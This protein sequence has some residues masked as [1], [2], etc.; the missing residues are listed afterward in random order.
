MVVV[1]KGEGMKVYIIWDDPLNMTVS[2]GKLR[3]STASDDLERLLDGIREAKGYRPMFYGENR[4]LEGW[5]DFDFFIS[6]NGI[7]QL[8]ATVCYAQSEDNNGWYDIPLTVE[9]RK[10]LR[11]MFNT[12]VLKETGKTIAECIKEETK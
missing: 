11:Q 10:E 6:E 8:L 2:D 5:Y 3:L 7:V 9:E 4:D 1:R 12:E